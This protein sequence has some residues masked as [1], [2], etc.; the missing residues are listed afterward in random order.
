MGEPRLTR[1]AL[2]RGGAVVAAGATAGVAL[3][4]AGRAAEPSPARD[5]AILRFALFLEDLQ[6]AFYA[7]A[8][9]RATLSGE[10]LEYA[11][12][13]GGH[14]RSHAAH[15]RRVLGS[16]APSPP[17]FDFRDAASDPTRFLETAITLEDLGVSAYNGAAASL[18]AD[19]LAD[20]ARIVS[21]EARHAAWVRDLAGK[22]P[23]PD[24]S[25][26]SVSAVEAKAVI[27]RL[28]FVV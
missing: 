21:V 2:L 26:P 8:L 3:A 22:S 17:R 7:D 24:A 5:R 16:A 9:A 14:E 15:V 6:A 11:Q 19:A 1:A 18:T 25:D 10:L 13:V 28:D 20:A 4:P 12:V 23:A 27:D